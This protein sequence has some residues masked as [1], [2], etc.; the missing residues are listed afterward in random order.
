MRFCSY[1][2]ATGIGIS[3]KK[4]KRKATAIILFSNVSFG[5]PK[6]T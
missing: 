4:V 6:L 2:Y 3:Q 5:K 1:F